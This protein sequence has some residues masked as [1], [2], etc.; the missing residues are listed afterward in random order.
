MIGSPIKLSDTPV[1]YAAAP[2]M[3][4]QHTDAV[5]REQLGLTQAQLDSLSSAGIISQ[6]GPQEAKGK[7]PK[8]A[9]D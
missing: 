1:T 7:T 9:V 8:I 4:G 2:P 3:L 5:L 6:L